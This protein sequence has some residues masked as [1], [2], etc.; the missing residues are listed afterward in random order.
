MGVNTKYCYSVYDRTIE[1]YVLTDVKLCVA[2]ELL[3]IPKDKVVQYAQ[4]GYVL[5]KRY[6]ISR[7]L[8]DGKIIEPEVE[9]FAIS[10]EFKTEWDDICLRLNPKA[11]DNHEVAV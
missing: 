1:Q 8:L 7:R 5:N 3:K 9:A 11:R 4:S 10:E 6:I 2:Y